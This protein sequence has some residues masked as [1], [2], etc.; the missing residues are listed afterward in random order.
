MTRRRRRRVRSR[1][2]SSVTDLAK[3]IVEA[4]LPVEPIFSAVV[5]RALAEAKGNYTHAARRVGLTR[6]QLAYRVKTAERFHAKA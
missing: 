6:A 1:V 5:E 4:G 2:A 3:T